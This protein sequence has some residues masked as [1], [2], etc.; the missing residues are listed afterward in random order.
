M[1]LAQLVKD[2]AHLCMDRV[3]TRYAHLFTYKGEFLAA[4]LP[5]K[6]MLTCNI[7]SGVS[8]LNCKLP[9][10]KEIMGKYMT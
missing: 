8:K 6:K 3:R 10:F 9:Y 7:I 5:N 1:N 4:R 2:I